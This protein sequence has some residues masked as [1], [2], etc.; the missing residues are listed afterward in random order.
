MN[1]FHHF[2]DEVIRALGQLAEAGRI[3]AGLDLARVTVEP[4]R[5]EGHGDLSTNAAMVLSKA[6]DLKPRA[7]A[8]LLAERLRAV[9]SISEVV[10][11]GPG[12]INLRVKET[13]WQARIADV[14]KAGTAYGSSTLGAGVRVN[15]EYVSANPTGPLHLAHARAPSS[16]MRWRR[17]W[18]R[19]A[20]P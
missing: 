9:A 18:P 4:P 3:P 10:V 7:L 12:F 19:S 6:A 16:A 20:L 2:R 5:E 8:E 15:V 17:C 11:A 14:L 13:F 1:V